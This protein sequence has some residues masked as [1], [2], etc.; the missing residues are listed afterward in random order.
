VPRVLLRPV[1]KDAEGKSIN[2]YNIRADEAGERITCVVHQGSRQ[3]AA[4]ARAFLEFVVDAVPQR[5][6]DARSILLSGAGGSAGG[7]LN[8]FRNRPHALCQTSS[9]PINAGFIHAVAADIEPID[10]SP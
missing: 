7:R 4:A 10:A 1:R 5:S 6:R 3:R 9:I 8:Q 2:L